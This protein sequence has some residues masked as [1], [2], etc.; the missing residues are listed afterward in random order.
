MS[1]ILS[2]KGGLVQVV[3]GNGQEE[4]WE[5]EIRFRDFIAKRKGVYR[6]MVMQIRIESALGTTLCT[7][8]DRMACLGEATGESAVQLQQKTPTFWRF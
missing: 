5:K 7:H 8:K 4:S 3:I 6:N 2:F 1:W